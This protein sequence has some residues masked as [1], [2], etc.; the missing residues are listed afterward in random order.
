L[1]RSPRCGWLACWRK[2]KNSRPRSG[3]GTNSA[4]AKNSNGSTRSA[5]SASGFA[6]S[7]SSVGWRK[8]SAWPPN[9][10]RLRIAAEQRLAAERRQADEQARRQEE[11]LNLEAR[12]KKEEE[13]LERERQRLAEAERLAQERKQ[14]EEQRVERARLA[15]AERLAL[16]RRQH[17]EQRQAAEQKRVEQQKLAQLAAAKPAPMPPPAPAQAAISAPAPARKPE[18]TSAVALPPTAPVIDI[19][20]GVAVPA[21][22][23]PSANPFSAG[24]YP[25]GRI[26]TL[27]DVAVVRQSDIL[28]GIEERTLSLRVTRVDYDEDRVEF[29]RGQMITDL[30]GNPIKNGPVEFDTPVQWTPAELQLGRKWT[31]AFR[32]TQ[33]GNTTNAYY[34]MHIAARETITVPAGRFDCFRIDGEGWNTPMRPPRA[35]A[36]AGAG[37]QLPIRRDFITRNRVRA[38][39]QTDK[40]RTRLAA[41]ADHRRPVMEAADSRP[42]LPVGTPVP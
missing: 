17:D 9:A 26:Y 13:R 10:R 34:D 20:A 6:S 25:L 11:K 16:E 36:V 15:E 33:G 14:Q 5:W 4:N 31:A 39:G 3:N 7:K 41:P 32:R 22:I 21:L 30:M 35:Q 1:P 40:E 27:G 28:T 8:S 23:A 42:A 24:R 37:H 2:S 38:F 29:N 12:R 19:Q 18:P